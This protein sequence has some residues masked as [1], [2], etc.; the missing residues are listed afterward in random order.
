MEIDRADIGEKKKADCIFLGFFAICDN[1]GRV[2]TYSI[3]DSSDKA[4]MLFQ[5]FHNNCD[6]EYAERYGFYSQKI[7]VHIFKK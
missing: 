5:S 7:D 6:R 2:M 4:W 3:A 1:G